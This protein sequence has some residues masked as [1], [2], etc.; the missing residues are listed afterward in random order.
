MRLYTDLAPWFHLLTAPEDYDEEA[1]RFRRAFS[2][3]RRAAPHAAGTR[4][5]RREHGVA[6][7]APRLHP[8]GSVA[9]DTRA[10]RAT[11]SRVEH[12]LGDMRTIRL[13][14]T[15]DA[16]FVHD[17]VMYLTTEDDLRLAIETASIHC[18]PGGVASSRPMPSARPS[19]PAPITA[20]TTGTGAPCA[21]SSQ[22]RPGGE[23]AFAVDYVVLVTEP[24]AD[25]RVVHDRHLHGLFAEHTWL[26]LL[27]AAGFAAHVDPGNPELEDEA[28]PVFVGRRPPSK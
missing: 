19:P 23:Q 15:F 1:A 11:Q 7:Q 18:R 13:G 14:R 3:D 10:E 4:L 20:A 24:G 6:P 25:A 27:E 8:H 21:T 16:V 5:R 26:Y 12:A 9:A 17:A 28:Q 22:R 2:E